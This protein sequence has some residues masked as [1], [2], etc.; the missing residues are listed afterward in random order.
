[1]T[2]RTNHPS[3]PTQRRS[4]MSLVNKFHHRLRQPLAAS[5]SSIHYDSL[6]VLEWDKLCDLIA[7]FATT[8]LG[9]EAV[10]V[11]LGLLTRSFLFASCLSSLFDVMAIDGASPAMVSN[12]T[13]DNDRDF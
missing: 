6:R 4:G 12:R 11:R 5:P 7:S 3:I 9:R 13:Y 1:M 8:S 10:K 2:S